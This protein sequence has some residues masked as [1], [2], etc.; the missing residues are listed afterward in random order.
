MTTAEQV[1]SRILRDVP[2][3]I[4]VV[5]ANGR[6]TFANP[7]AV[8][9]LG[10]QD[11]REFLGKPS[12]TTVH[13]CPPDRPGGDENCV[14]LA[15]AR[16]GKA[17]HG[18]SESFIRRDGSLFPIAWWSSPI[19]LP[20]GR[21]VVL[22]FTDI[23]ERLRAEQTARERDAATIRATEAKAAQR[24]IM[25][26]TTEIRRQIARNLHD[27]AQQR[28][29][30][31]MVSLELARGE[32]APGDSDLRVF[33]DSSVTETQSAIDELRELVAGLHPPTLQC[34]GLMAAIQGLADRMPIPSRITSNLS[35]RLSESVEA[36]A[37]YAVAEAMANAVK[38]AGANCV[39]VSVSFDGKEL[40][41]RVTDDGIGGAWV[42]TG[43]GLVGL[44]DRIG[45]HDGKVEV[46]SP[47]G[48]GTTVR[49]T[50]PVDPKVAGRRKSVK[51][52]GHPLREV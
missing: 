46:D 32:L 1:V 35:R 40:D 47:R 33:L 6:I 17:A 41:I 14:L 26:Q 52:G 49:I 21:G 48:G 45:A 50:I 3:P 5:D 37:Y 43:S 7:A 30:A 38:H 15:P 16:T 24:R 20:T 9:A 28:L 12:H 27:G 4:W 31:L 19:E 10:Y 42:G 25:E 11:N 8:A 29:V 2:Q 22:A 18:E 51:P 39:T 23:T 34:Y 36:S 44:V 13:Y